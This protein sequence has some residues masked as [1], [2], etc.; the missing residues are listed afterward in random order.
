MSST[1]SMLILFVTLGWHL[2]LNMLNLCY[3]F[4][5][6]AVSKLWYLCVASHF[7]FGFLKSGSILCASDMYKVGVVS[8]SQCLC[9]SRE[10]KEV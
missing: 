10:Q 7:L 5:W 8:A 1:D 2:A 6:Y 4:I 3:I 9:I